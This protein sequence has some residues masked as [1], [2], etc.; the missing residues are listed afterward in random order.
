MDIEWLA[1]PPL[2]NQKSS[3]TDTA[4]RVEIFYE[5]LYYLVDSLLIPLIRSNF[6]VTESSAHRYRVFFF[7]HDI[8]RHV[9]EPAMATLK[10]KMFEEVKLDDARRIL[11]SRRLG[12]SQVRLLPKGLAMR[13]IMNLRRR[14]LVK[15]DRKLLGPSINTILG[16]VNHMLKLEKVM[17]TCNLTFCERADS[18][19]QELDP[20]RLGSAMFSVGDIYK[21]IKEFKAAVGAHNQRFY[22]AKVDVQAAFD[23]IP[24]DAMVGL[25]SRVP[26]QPGYKVLKHLEVRPS[27]MAQGPGSKGKPVRK[28][29]SVAK[30]ANDKT[31]FAQMLEDQLAPN[32]KNTVFVENV[33]RKSY[34]T[35]GLMALLSSHVQQNLVKIGKKYYRQKNGIPQGS[36][37]SSALCNY[38]YADLE[39]NRLPFLRSDDC[40]LLRLIDDSVLIT[41]DKAKAQRFV[42]T[43]HRGL[44]EYGVIVSPGKSLVNF[45]LSVD[46]ITIPRTVE[47]QPFPYCGT[48]ID[49]KSLDITRNRDNTKDSGMPPSYERIGLYTLTKPVVFDSLT[50]ESSRYPGQNFR[51]KTLSTFLRG[52]GFSFIGHLTDTILKTPSRSNPTSCSLTHLIIPSKPCSPTSTTPSW[53]LQPSRGL[54]SVV[55]QRRSGRQPS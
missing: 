47:G 55:C 19:C 50:V 45:D 10:A 31:A 33:L 25:I 16:P 18:C 35:R 28:W 44:P 12:F 38:F 7:R 5:F 32:K 34:D 51:R 30:A 49:C 48:L 22:F 8:W 2:K 46:S 40:L 26:S 3:C 15:G 11:D 36:V 43:M 27:D 20:A 54:T 53:R 14:T 39:M 21:R 9:A 42:E 24:Q 23:T 4:K 52:P 41:T 1:P 13:P 29:Q 17:G 37:I 6:Y